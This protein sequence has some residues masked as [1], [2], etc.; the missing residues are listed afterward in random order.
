MDISPIQ[1]LTQ[2]NKNPIWPI[3][4]LTHVIF[5]FGYVIIPLDSL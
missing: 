2:Q 4:I 5:Y 3:Q 1:I